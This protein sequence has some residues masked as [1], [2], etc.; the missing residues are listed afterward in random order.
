MDTVS[1][2]YINIRDPSVFNILPD[3]IRNSAVTSIEIF[4]K[5]LHKYLQLSDQPGSR[6]KARLREEKNLLKF[7]EG[8]IT[9]LLK[10]LFK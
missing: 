10:C 7:V 4:K 9:F 2:H 1:E 8:N 6:P 5:N 3:I